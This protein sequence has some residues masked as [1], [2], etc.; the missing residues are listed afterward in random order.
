MGIFWKPLTFW[1]TQQKLERKQSCFCR[2]L[3]ALP[4]L[5]NILHKLNLTS[6]NEPTWE[7][8]AKVS[9]FWI[10]LIFCQLPSHLPSLLTCL[11]CGNFPWDIRECMLKLAFVWYFPFLTPLPKSWKK[12]F[13]LNLLLFWLPMFGSYIYDSS[14]IVFQTKIRHCYI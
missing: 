7:P 3:S 6:Y 9:R 5:N 13:E 8:Y 12:L 1:K 2:Q 4:S 10:K 11:Q 14:K